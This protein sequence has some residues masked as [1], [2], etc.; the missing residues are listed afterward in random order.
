MNDDFEIPQ[1]EEM[2]EDFDLPEEKVGDEREVGDRGL[3]K[4]LLK[5]GEGWDTPEFGD[6]VQGTTIRRR[7]HL[8]SFAFFQFSV[9]IN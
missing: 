7:F 3:K 9:L 6:E 5:L 2:N 1:A 8:S 4:K